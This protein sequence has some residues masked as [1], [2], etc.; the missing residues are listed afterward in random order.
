[1]RS[2]RRDHVLATVL[3]TD[4]V[5]SS[6]IAAELGDRR[7]RVLLARHNAIVRRALK[8]RGGKEIDNAGDGFFA[9]FDDQA[10][11]IRCACEISDAVRDLGIE[12]RAGLHVGQSEIV[13]KKLGGTSI[14]IASRVM[15][16]AAA[17]EVLVSG[18]MRD[19]VA[20]SGFAFEDRG[21]HRLKG[22]PGEWRLY[23]ITAVDGTARGPSLEPEAA[24]RARE[25]IKPPPVLE[26]R[27]A[28]R[29]GVAVAVLAVALVSAAILRSRD[30]PPA[31][32]P[33]ALEIPRNSLVRIDPFTSE[34]VAVV[35]LVAPADGQMTA[36]PERQE[37]W[38]LSPKE[39]VISV[40]DADTN[41][42]GS[43]IPGFGGATEAL[44]YGIVYHAG[45]V[46]VIGNDNTVHEIGT[47]LGNPLAA[48]D[49]PNEPS[50]LA[51]GFGRVWVQFARR[52]RGIPP[53]GP[54][55]IVAIDPERRSP[56]LE[57]TSS[58]GTNGIA[59]GEGAVWVSESVFSQ[60]A[61]GHVVRVDPRTAQAILK[62][63]VGR[64]PADIGIG[65][66]SV[67]VSN[68][69]DGTVSR[70]DPSTDHV[71][72]TI[73]VGGRSESYLAGGIAPAAGSMWV[74]VPTQREVVRIDPATNQVEERIL[75]PT[76]G[77]PFR[78]IAA[79]GSIWVTVS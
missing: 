16:E 44:G 38:V 42:A 45:S 54:C 40:V 37:V 65:F 34:I 30:A 63:P 22:I 69:W 5:G 56:V 10:D 70:I 1:M 28:R 33:P 2:G 74:A 20:G 51:E 67:W 6:E 25:S 66:D 64:G 7:W 68:V 73:E 60:L 62:I 3:F 29:I 59:V 24:V 53:A 12:I 55:V 13:G 35:P 8:R 4:I 47:A 72:A 23:A 61:D 50:L 77:I 39:Q 18:V 14:H 19:L 31:E 52:R 79:F 41:E 21:V 46:W 43:P 71:V 11:A 36:V 76:L 15:S 78:L 49:V 75:L 9:A 57:A 48:I 32:P 17:G 27:G 58:C 26:R